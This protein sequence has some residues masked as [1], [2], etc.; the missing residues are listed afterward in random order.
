[1]SSANNSDNKQIAIEPRLL[2]EKLNLYEKVL[3]KKMENARINLEL[4]DMRE[5]INQYIDNRKKKLDICNSLKKSEDNTLEN[6]RKTLDNLSINHRQL[7]SGRLKCSI[8]N[9]EE[10]EKIKR[11]KLEKEYFTL[12]ED[13]N[14]LK[15]E[16][17]N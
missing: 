7:S 5:S 16:V 1:M 10:Y 4:K 9:D 8:V 15:E 14:Q 3:K 13:L 2:E 6:N 17:F 11:E 12:L